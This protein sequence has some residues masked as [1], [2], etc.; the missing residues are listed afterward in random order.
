MSP[1]LRH[2]WSLCVKGGRG[3]H[4][5]LRSPVLAPLPHP[6]T[7]RPWAQAP[8]PLPKPTLPLTLLENWLDVGG[9]ITAK[10]LTGI[11]QRG[12]RGELLAKLRLA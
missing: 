3:W 7:S 11:A 10:Q 9:V 6:P 1:Y 4:P 8:L 5:V 12:G 2:P